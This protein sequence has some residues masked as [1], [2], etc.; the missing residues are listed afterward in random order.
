MS[1]QLLCSQPAALARASCQKEM[2]EVD[3]LGHVQATYDKLKSEVPKYKMI[4]TS[5][6]SDRLKVLCHLCPALAA[7]Y[8]GLDAAACAQ[9]RVL[10]AWLPEWSRP[11]L[12]C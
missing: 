2:A 3:G 6:L 1:G 12:S 4:T 10:K 9:I 11:P 7:A 5:I 8:A